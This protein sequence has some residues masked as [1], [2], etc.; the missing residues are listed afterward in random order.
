[1]EWKIRENSRGGYDAQYG[2]QHEGGAPN[3]NGIGVT[4]P[5]FIVYR[6][7]HFDTRTETRY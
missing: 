2:V 7:A 6:S 4:M 3:W 5:A 1:M